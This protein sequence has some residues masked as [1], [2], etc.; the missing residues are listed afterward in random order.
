L[1]RC[2]RHYVR[3]GKIPQ[4]IPSRSPIAASEHSIAECSAVNN[5]F[6][7]SVSGNALDLLVI[8]QTFPNQPSEQP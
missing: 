8:Q 2:Q 4:R 7:S 5:A 1:R 3:L 6:L